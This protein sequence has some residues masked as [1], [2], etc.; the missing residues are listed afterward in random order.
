MGGQ[1]WVSAQIIKLSALQEVLSFGGAWG[2]AI[3]DEREVSM[4]VSR[5]VFW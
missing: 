3:A 4:T 5:C 1:W 2:P